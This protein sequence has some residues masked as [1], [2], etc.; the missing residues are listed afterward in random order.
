LLLQ[1]AG[2]LIYGRG[3]WG[4]VVEVAR[5]LSALKSPE[6]R[7]HSNKCHEKAVCNFLKIK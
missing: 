7:F 2:P 5:L 3:L 1:I 6:S 4:G